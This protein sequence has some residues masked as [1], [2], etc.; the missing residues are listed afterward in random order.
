MPDRYDKT[1]HIYYIQ[2]FGKAQP[3]KHG[4]FWAEKLVHLWKRTQESGLAVQKLPG[5]LDGTGVAGVDHMEGVWLRQAVDGEGADGLF[6]G[7]HGLVQKAD[8]D[9]VGHQ[10]LD[11][12]EAADGVLPL[13]HGYLHH[14]GAA[15]HDPAA[16]GGKAAP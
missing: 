5:V 16:P 7:G 11:G 4:I 8:A 14:Q 13:F 9:A 6:S 3:V 1:A 10:G 12:G 2:L 15:G